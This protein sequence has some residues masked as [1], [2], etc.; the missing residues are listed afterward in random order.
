MFES[1][2]VLIDDLQRAD[3]GHLRLFLE[4]AG[5]QTTPDGKTVEVA[6]V[7]AMGP[8]LVASRFSVN[9]PLRFIGMS[10]RPAAWG[11]ILKVEASALRD[12]GVDGAALLRAPSKLLLAQL[13]EQT[14]LAD[15]A[16]LLDAFFSA[17]IRPIPAEHSFLNERIR[18]WLAAS[19]YPDV[20]DLYAACAL[21]DRQVTRICNKYWGAP[22]KALARKYG[23]LRTAS[24]LLAADGELPAEAL[25]HY[26]DKP[27]LIREIKRVTG[28]PPRR[29]MTISHMIMRMT[30]HEANFRELQP[31]D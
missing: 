8:H 24:R 30:L 2:Q 13:K 5:H 11:G 18:A 6:Q 21:T 27:H 19:L 16:P 28:L 14:N 25:A 10:M 26:A 9:G 7:Q 3:C 22:P 20:D 12:S 23:A 17:T 31:F 15:M 29:L 1:D 4:G